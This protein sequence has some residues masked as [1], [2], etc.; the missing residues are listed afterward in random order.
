[1]TR[2]GRARTLH[3][4]P[5]SLSPTRS[6][7][8]AAAAV[9]GITLAISNDHSAASSIV[10]FDIAAAGVW[11]SGALVL[12][13]DTIAGVEPFHPGTV[14]PRAAQLDDGYAAC[15]GAI[16][17]SAG[18]PAAVVKVL[19]TSQAG[20]AQ[21]LPN[22]LGGTSL[23]GANPVINYL[24][25]VEIE[26]V[27]DDGVPAPANRVGA[28]N[29][30]TGSRIRLSV[31]DAGGRLLE[32]VEADQGA[33]LGIA[34]TGIARARF[35]HVQSQSVIGFSL[36]DVT[37]GRESIPADLNGDGAVDGADLGPLLA[38]WGECAQTC[39]AGD[40]NLDG[41]IDGADIGLLLG[42]WTG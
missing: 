10:T 26:F 5:W 12:G 27:D 22:I 1:M 19:G 7:A 11:Q 28:W 35:D 29:D 42:D 24:S 39:C 20:D 18:G 14:V 32:S 41:A 9:G 37:V 23:S 3:R 31:F 16:F 17:S 33:F 25:F 15:A 21:S 6:T 40:L 4:W 34:A 30:P 38:A 36:D 2:P 8:F 13:F